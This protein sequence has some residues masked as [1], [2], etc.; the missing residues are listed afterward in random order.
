MSKPSALFGTQT[1]IALPA[2][3]LE[4]A[5]LTPAAAAAAAELTVQLRQVASQQCMLTMPAYQGLGLQKPIGCI[6]RCFKFAWRSL[7]AQ[8][9]VR[10]W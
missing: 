2:A 6:E 9:S 7:L 1:A 5:E 3:F 10:A 4:T 8:V